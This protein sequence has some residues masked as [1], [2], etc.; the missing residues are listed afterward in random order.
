M[1]LGPV[2]K[3]DKR[4]ATTSKKYD[5]DVVSAN[6]D[7]II[8]FRISNWFGAVRNPEARCMVYVS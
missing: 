4:N 8:I 5:D 3:H 1:K 6:Y 7:A 2:T